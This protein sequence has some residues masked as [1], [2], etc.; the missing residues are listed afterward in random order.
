MWTRVSS[1]ALVMGIS[2]LG[3]ALG[4]S[5]ANHGHGTQ[6]DAVLYELTEH[7]VLDAQQ[8]RA[9]ASLEGAARRGSPLCPE[10]LQAY[11]K[12]AFATFG[13]RVKVDPRCALVAVGTS[14]IS[15][16][17][18]DGTIG[19]KFWVVVNSDATNLT[20]AQELVI[21]SGSFAGKVQVINPPDGHTIEILPEST[22]TSEWVVDGFPLSLP[23]TFSFSGT[24]RLPL[25]VHHIA[26]YETDGGRLVPVLPNERALGKPN[27]RL[28]VDF[29]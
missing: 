24:F 21:M 18:F 8:R 10:G 2:L 20:D 4:T 11:A 17:D 3:P 29:E 9:T 7:A 16:K 22:F 28:E 12:A 19:G 14:E 25:T 23:A 15:L 26:V 27:V 6:P 1:G 13:I 5:E